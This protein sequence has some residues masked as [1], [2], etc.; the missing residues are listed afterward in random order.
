MI[1]EISLDFAFKEET[2][3]ENLEQGI[4]AIESNIKVGLAIIAVSLGR[5]RREKLYLS[6]CPDFKS[7]CRLDRFNMSYNKLLHLSIIGENWWNHKQAL[8][9]NGI[10]LSENMS[11]IRL[12]TSD[13]TETI[14]KSPIFFQRFKELSYREL[15]IYIEKKRNNLNVRTRTSDEINVTVT[16]KGLYV[17]GEKVRGID[18]EEVRTKIAN[19]KRAVI[20]WVNNDAEAQKVRRLFKKNT[21]T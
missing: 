6:L 7:Y 15:K 9:D 3:L 14:Q 8:H 16:R 12:L 20:I 10:K 2:T 13:L 1:E 4:R 17:D 18:M 19:G 21:F 5:V 11:K